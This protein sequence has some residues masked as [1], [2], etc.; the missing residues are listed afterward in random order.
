M[1]VKDRDATQEEARFPREKNAMSLTS[2]NK[3]TRGILPMSIKIL[4]VDDNSDILANVA[5]YLEMKVGSW[6]AAL[7]RQMPGSECIAATST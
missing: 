7:P 2:R 5:E 4:V 3:T 1:G 6:S